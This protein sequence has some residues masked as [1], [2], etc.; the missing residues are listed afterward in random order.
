M[1][2]TDIIARLKLNAE[3]FTNE[4][5]RSLGDVEKKFGATG[6]VLGRNI[7][8]G[9]GAGLQELT[10]RIP[11]VGGALTGL[12]GSALLA[13]GGI[14]AIS[15][16]LI[17][18]VSELEGYNN[19]V[20]GLNAVLDATGNKTALATQQLLDFASELE[21]KFSIP[22]EEIISAEKA[23]ASFDGV[24]GTTFKRAIAG[25]ADMSAVFGGDLSSNTEK[26]GVALQN[27]AQGNVEGLGKAFKFLGKDAL[28]TIAHLAEVGKTAEA[29][30]RLL[31]E[32]A[33]HIGGAAESGAGGLSGAFFR[34]ADAVGDATRKMADQ[35]GILPALIKGMNALSRDL[36]GGVSESASE[37]ASRLGIEAGKARQRVV[38]AQAEVDRG[39]G[40]SAASRLAAAKRELD[41]A[42]RSANAAIADAR[43]EAQ[44]FQREQDAAAEAAK[45]AYSNRE[46]T[47]DKSDKSRGSNRADQEKRVTEQIER[48]RVEL[49]H[50]LEISQLRAE[51]LNHEADLQEALYRLYSQF[52]GIDRA[53]LAE[54]E[55]LIR[56]QIEL[57]EAVQAEK[58]FETG[59]KA[60]Q[61]NA[62]AASAEL[63]RQKEE[64]ERAAQQQ[65]SDL[66]DYY[67]TLFNGGTGSIWKQFKAEGK[68]A[69]A[70]IAAAY[71]LA[72][73]SGQKPTIE[74]IIGGLS[75][76]Q[77]SVFSSQGGGL[78]GQMMGSVFGGAQGVMPGDMPGLPG[79]I[80]AG[81]PG[82]ASGSMMGGGGALGAISAGAG[83]GMISDSIMGA[84]GIKSSGAGAAIGGTIGSVLGPPGMIIGSI[85]GGLLGGA[86]KKTKKG[87]S[88]LGFDDGGLGI[89]S[90]RGNSGSRKQASIDAGNSIIDALE[91]I[92]DQMGGTLNGSIST[93]IGMRNKSYVVDTTG[94]GRTKGAGVEKF[95]DQQAAIEAAI[96]DALV[97]GVI[98][99]ISEASKKILREGK[100]LQKAIDQAVEI[101]SIP[102]RIKAFENPLGAAVDELNA[103]WQKTIAALKA[104]GATSEQWADAQKLYSLE[105]AQVKSSTESAAAQLKD[106]ADS[107][108]F[109]SSSPLSLR[110][111]EAAAK[112]ALQPYLDQING[113][114]AVD[115]AGYQKAAQAFLDIER[116]LFGSTDSFFQQFNAI[117]EATN[118]A[119][120]A[121]D[122]AQPIAESPFVQATAQATQATAT[123]TT[124]TSEIL[125]QQ[126]QLLANQNA[127]L[128]QILQTLQANG[129]FIGAIR[130]FV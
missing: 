30:Q 126:S 44:E 121:V 71:T 109:G 118:K 11:V 13:A 78:F 98:G 10:A 15:A 12:S 64:A 120:A 37:R 41:A 66:A 65:I 36:G 79:G 28:D 47:K 5:N 35:L 19:A 20:R 113:G 24:A 80:G 46:N 89:T 23:L 86:L 110:D 101:E 107:L 82:G 38:A 95:K 6:G 22:E 114:S 52:P 124:A 81:L 116:Q 34:L 1:S 117:Q 45:L 123:A 40:L 83:V 76:G 43:K 128:A 111:Q 108:M 69:I 3:G 57:N 112:A 77:G 103:K 68:R 25:A 100:D 33:S 87:I 92:A 51:G 58:D 90:T 85:I 127:T 119:I 4:L 59:A 115:Q 130:N 54:H 32:L 31:D 62:R 88:T 129:M 50:G 70:E 9:I 39:G 48:Q 8:T 27:L 104:G 56:K 16:V 122:K 84:L 97:D 94:Q 63:A 67:E 26:L 74:G 75:G 61:K 105:L 60:A 7:S 91:Q 102:K 49:E 73:L 18:G 53:R 2:T 29:Q 106:F 93:S 72:V 17:K 14:G 99:G 96:R 125:S 21:G 42:E 55:K